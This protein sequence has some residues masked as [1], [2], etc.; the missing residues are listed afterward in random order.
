MV[1]L[2]FVLFCVCVRVFVLYCIACVWCVC[3]GMRVVCVCACALCACVCCLRVVCV[4]VCALCV[5][6]C[7]LSCR[8]RVTANRHCRRNSSPKRHVGFFLTYT[9]Y[10][11]V[12]HGKSI[13]YIEWF[14]FCLLSFILKERKQTVIHSIVSQHKYT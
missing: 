14:I 2:F 7:V 6:V 9:N 3:V 5:I 13:I 10:F 12:F 4:C 11:R 8:S 1:T